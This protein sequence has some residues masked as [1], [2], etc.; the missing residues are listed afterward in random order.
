MDPTANLGFATV[1]FLA[2]HYVSST[3]LRPWL[4]GA[5]GEKPFL[6]AYSAA[7]LVTLVWMCW[8]YVQAPREM[9][10]TPLRHAPAAVLPFAFIL[11][12]CGYFR[13]PTMVMAERLLKS[14]DPARGMIRVTRHPIMWGIMLWGGAHILARAD[15]KAVV[16]FGAF[17]LLAASGSVLSDERKARELG[18][19]WKRFASV[20]SH[21]PFAAIAQ[22]RNRLVLRELGWKL[23]LL[24]VALYAAFL[25]AHGWLFGA[26][27]W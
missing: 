25:A 16:F 14:D 10:W 15:L 6:G 21:L 4:V 18:E 3:R 9:L 13:N 24:G 1:T 27:P 22:G 7:A 11:I 20:T 12:A 17:I 2:A 8:A 23:P 19:D 5:L 26:T